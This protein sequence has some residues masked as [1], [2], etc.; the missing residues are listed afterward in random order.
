M[1]H[2]INTTLQT[3]ICYCWVIHD[4]I[5]RRELALSVINNDNNNNN[6]FLVLVE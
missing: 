1:G 4:G 6:G 2:T 3:S 5:E